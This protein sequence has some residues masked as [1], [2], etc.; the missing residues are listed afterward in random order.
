M[1]L[2]VVCKEV[3]NKIL[4]PFLDIIQKY[5]GIVNEVKEVS[6]YSSHS[7]ISDDF[8][9]EGYWRHSIHGKKHWVSSHNKSITTTNYRKIKSNVYK[10]NWTR[11]VKIRNWG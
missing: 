2:I 11:E 3:S 9:V 10:V 1:E 8:G 6:A 4:E 5:G 7:K